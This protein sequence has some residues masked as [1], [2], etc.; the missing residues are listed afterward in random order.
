MSDWLTKDR[1]ETYIDR[2]PEVLA[3]S[4]VIVKNPALGINLYKNVLTEEISTKCI[5]TLESELSNSGPY[6]WSPA[7]VTE[8]DNPLSD[9]R[10]CLDFK[11][12]QG[13]LGD[14]TRHNAHLYDI[15]KAT[16]DAIYPASQHYGRYW[17]VGVNYFETFN[18]VKYQGAG[19]HFNIHADHGP[20]YVCTVSMVGYLN[21]D[22]DGGEIYFPRFDLEIKPEAGDLIIFP[23]TYIYEHASKPIINGTKYSVVIMTDYNSR[24]NLRYHQY[25]QNDEELIY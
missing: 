12:G 3:Y 7:Q 15:H 24:G 4:N 8:S 22:Y 13:N 1:S 23:S 17:G 2:L 21:D 20:A 16:F 18:F 11:I 10:N 19:T 5:N 14:R 9:A 6:R 25:R